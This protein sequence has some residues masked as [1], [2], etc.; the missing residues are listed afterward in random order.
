[1]IFFSGRKFLKG[2]L[3]ASFVV[4]VFLMGITILDRR[5]L[6]VKFWLWRALKVESRP[7]DLPPRYVLI[8]QSRAIRSMSQKICEI[9]AF[10]LLNYKSTCDLTDVQAL[11]WDTKMDARSFDGT[12][13]I[14]RCLSFV[15]SLFKDRNASIWR[16]GNR[17]VKVI[18]TAR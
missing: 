5:V 1:M 16:I 4:K 18:L 2:N 10:D 17:R 13:K 11:I 8:S 9:W 3:K 6:F 12:H 7:S 14:L 15:Q